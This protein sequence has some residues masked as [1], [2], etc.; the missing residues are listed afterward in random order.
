MKKKDRIKYL[1]EQVSH[2]LY[3]L[4]ITKALIQTS[5]NTID[6]RFDNINKK[7]TELHERVNKIRSCIA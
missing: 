2:L 5:D 4:N 6:Y 1:E 7:V 3:E